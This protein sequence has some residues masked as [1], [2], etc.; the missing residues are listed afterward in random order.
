MKQRLHKIENKISRDGGNFALFSRGAAEGSKEFSELI[1]AAEGVSRANRFCAIN[2]C[3]LFAASADP[4][5]ILAFAQEKGHKSIYISAPGFARWQADGTFFSYF[6]EGGTF[7]YLPD[8]ERKLILNARKNNPN[9]FVALLR[10]A[11][12]HF[13]I[14]PEPEEN[15]LR[16][17]VADSLFEIIQAAKAWRISN[18]EIEDEVFILGPKE[19][20]A[21]W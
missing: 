5:K 12:R 21:K 19:G 15:P 4:E 20:Y 14:Q 3:G 1:S 18:K 16:V 6:G 17:I 11:P 10:E 2:F 9:S 7:S 8:G 13:P